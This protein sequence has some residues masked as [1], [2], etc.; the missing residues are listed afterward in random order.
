MEKKHCSILAVTNQKG[1]V[2]KTTTAVNIAA[3]LAAAERKVL[4]IDL[5]PQSN[6]SSNLGISNSPLNSSA[7]EILLRPHKTSFSVCSTELKFL[8]VIPGHAQLGEAE[9]ELAK[10]KNKETRLATFLAHVR[11]DFDNIIIDCPP[12]L[13]LLTVNALCAATSLLI[14]LQCEYFAL[15]G[16]SQMV[17][18]VNTVRRNLNR[19]LEI[20]G[21]L[22]TMYDADSQ[23]CLE[24]ER[25]ARK[26]FGTLLWDARIPRSLK[27][28]EA[29][30]F[31]RPIILHDIRSSGALSYMGAAQE[32]LM[33]RQAKLQAAQ[34]KMAFLREG[35][36]PPSHLQTL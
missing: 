34:S 7:H 22:L 28:S 16:L 12:S 29:Q 30:S 33:R 25:D 9:A 32:F 17:R 10:A 35:N 23:L 1:G 5:D 19:A 21:I 27:L 24:V 11:A 13:G 8:S 31:G 2:G 3:C 15:D 4:L 20:E 6:A 18:T 14:P 26:H 36:N